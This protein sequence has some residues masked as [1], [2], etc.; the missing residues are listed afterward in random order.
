[1]CT[2][3]LEVLGRA[4]PSVLATTAPHRGGSAAQCARVVDNG[5]GVHFGNLRFFATTE[6]ESFESVVLRSLNGCH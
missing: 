1:M 4:V 2:Y 5:V 6:G 3:T